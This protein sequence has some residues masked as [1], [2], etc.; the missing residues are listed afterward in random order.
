MAN[1]QNRLYISCPHKVM[2]E[3]IQNQHFSKGCLMYETLISP[4]NML[5]GEIHTNFYPDVMKMLHKDKSVI[6]E[7]LFKGSAIL[8]FLRK[9]GFNTKLSLKSLIDQIDLRDAPYCLSKEDI[10]FSNALREAG[11]SPANAFGLRYNLKISGF[12]TIAYWQKVN[13]NNT[14]MPTH[15]EMRRRRKSIEYTFSTDAPPLPVIRALM[16]RYPAAEMAYT[17]EIAGHA[18][19]LHKIYKS[20]FGSLDESTFFAA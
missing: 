13:W 7:D 9:V 16:T 18:K 3:V 10:E 8:D 20:S 5:G 14:T 4:P 11:I 2:M 6:V 17:C 19:K 15:N 12:P 1:C